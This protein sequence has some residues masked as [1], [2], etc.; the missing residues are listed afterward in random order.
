MQVGGDFHGNSKKEHAWENLSERACKKRGWKRQFL[1]RCMLELAASSRLE[2]H[3]S[4]EDVQMLQIFMS[5]MLKFE[6]PNDDDLFQNEF[7]SG[8]KRENKFSP[9]GKMN[10]FWPNMHHSPIKSFPNGHSREQ[11]LEANYKNTRKF[12]KQENN[13]KGIRR[14]TTFSQIDRFSCTRCSLQLLGLSKPEVAHDHIF[15]ATKQPLEEE[16]RV[17]GVVERNTNVFEITNGTTS[18][19]LLLWFPHIFL[20]LCLIKEAIL[21]DRERLIPKPIKNLWSFFGFR[22]VEV[23]HRSWNYFQFFRMK[24]KIRIFVLKK[25]ENCSSCFW[26]GKEWVLIAL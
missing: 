19:R 21:G 26:S 13:H 6:S 2:L 20:F 15:A 9:L 12:P 17:G 8:Q 3:A 10:I 5:K 7:P 11:C 14:L 22:C 18:K 16:E 4:F 23:F 25:A 1:N 24:M